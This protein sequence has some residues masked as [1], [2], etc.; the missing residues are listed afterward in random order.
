[1]SENPIRLRSDK[2]ND[3]KMS[4]KSDPITLGQKKYPK[5]VHGQKS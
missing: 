1:M 4:E 2:K 5:N 3:R